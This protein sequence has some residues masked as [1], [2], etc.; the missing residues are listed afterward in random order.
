MRISCT[1]CGSDDV[2]I[3]HLLAAECP[4]TTEARIAKAWKAYQAR[5]NVSRGAY[6]HFVAGY[7]AAG[8]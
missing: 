1:A 7:L 4:D 6:R 5:G 3:A 8:R 2:D